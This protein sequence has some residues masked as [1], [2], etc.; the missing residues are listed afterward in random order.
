MLTCTC[1]DAIIERILASHDSIPSQTWRDDL[2]VRL[3]RYLH[4]VL[5]GNL[6]DLTFGKWPAT[7]RRSFVQRGIDG[8]LEGR[9]L[10]AAQQRMK[11]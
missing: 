6:R 11:P 2:K 10:S 7:G 8:D 5:V 9:V 3:Q 1:P 4:P